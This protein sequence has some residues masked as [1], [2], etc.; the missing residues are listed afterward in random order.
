M[1]RN[2][3][4]LVLTG[5]TGIGKT[6]LSFTIQEELGSNIISADSRQVY[7]EMSIGTAK[8]T[9]QEV[10]KYRIQCCDYVSI[11]DEYNAGVFVKD[12]LVAAQ[13]DWEDKGFCFLC[14]GTG[15]YIK[16]F[17]DGLDSFPD[18]PVALKEKWNNI[19]KTEGLSPLQNNLKQ[20]DPEYY[21]SV[22]TNNPHRLI[23]ALSVIEHSGQ[24]YSSFLNK[25][26]HNDYEVIHIVL[27]LPRQHIYDRINKRV[28]G[29]MQSGLLEEVESL[30]PFKDLKALN[31]VGYAELF[32]YLDGKTSI[33][34][35][36]A[37]IQTHSRQYAKRQITWQKKYN[38]GPRF[39]P[40]DKSAVMEYIKSALEL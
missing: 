17:C 23:R 40:D 26:S 10:S 16:S 30:Y 19:Y 5:P 6:E 11:H 37:G 32:H 25:T 14:G 3:K 8:P 33:E 12:A 9:V 4:I 27:D 31:T 24:P 7:K 18:I 34:N 21:D 39:R 13:A 36:I 2:K 1:R 22:D 38:P 20:L 15:L 29:M 28:L 35:S